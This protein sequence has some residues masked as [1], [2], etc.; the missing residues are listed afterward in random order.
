MV[1]MMMTT[2]IMLPCRIETVASQSWTSKARPPEVSKT[3]MPDMFC[4]SSNDTIESLR[5]FLLLASPVAFAFHR[6]LVSVQS[7]IGGT[8]P[9]P[10]EGEGSRASVIGV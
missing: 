9:V 8:R 6:P 7:G 2:L 10:T 4:Q 5:A 3:F 1:M